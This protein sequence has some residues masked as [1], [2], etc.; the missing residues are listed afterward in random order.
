MLGEINLRKWLSLMML[1]Y[2]ADDK[3]SELLR[4]A[5]LR[6]AFCEL[7]AGKLLG[8]AGESGA[9]HTVGMFS[10]LPAMLDKPMADIL[11]ELAL[12]SEVKEALLG[13]A[14]GPLLQTLRLVT[15]YERGEWEPVVTLAKALT[16]PLAELPWLYEAALETLQGFG[17]TD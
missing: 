5:T 16:V 7:I 2:M 14:A 13:N 6:G 9:F 12:S 3:P 4:L 10:L 15:A 8:R 11:K 17:F 1:S